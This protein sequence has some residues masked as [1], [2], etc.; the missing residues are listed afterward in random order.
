M[1]RPE[2]DL[3]VLS[4]GAETT[5]VAV[6]EASLAAGLRP[7]VLAVE[8]DSLL[9]DLDGVPW[10]A[11][12]AGSTREE[13]A[14]SLVD[15]LSGLDISQPT[16]VLPTEDDGLSILH[17]AAPRLAPTVRFSRAKALRSGGLDKAELFEALAA[18]AL[19][20]AIAPTLLLSRPEDFI[21]AVEQLGTDCIVKPAFKP[22]RAALGPD[23]LKV[24]SRRGHEADAAVVERIRA[25]WTLC[26]RWIA[27]ARLN[28]FDGAERSAAVV[29][30]GGRIVG[31][32]VRERLK[33][34]RMGGTAVWVESRPETDLLDVA[35]R[36]ADA[37]DLEGIC[38]LSFLGGPDGSPRLLELNT[39]PWLQVELVERSG[40]PIISETVCALRDAHLPV[41]AA[42]IVPHH[43][44]QPERWLLALLRGDRRAALGNLRSILRVPR[45]RRIWSIW[46]S[47]LPGMRTRWLRK[48]VGSAWR[49]VS[50]GLRPART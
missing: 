43:W 47:E 18:A 16:I 35:A 25:V 8:S 39:R 3:V 12:L 7:A 41:T 14:D 36:I 9:R 2:L 37:I 45:S 49:R 27:Q 38:E 40:F 44:M 46:S 10:F 28:T 26:P 19:D 30:G 48:V 11:V 33:H 5:A 13:L 4:G 50:A 22:W 17:A 24:I 20:D 34:P 32:E 6:V 21:S 15:A 42:Q 1:A 23:G 31:C 29:R